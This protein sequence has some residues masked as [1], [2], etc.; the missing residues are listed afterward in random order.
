MVIWLHNPHAENVVAS[1]A[2][3]CVALLGLAL[4]AWWQ[5]RVTEK[6]WQHLRRMHDMDPQP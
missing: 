6:R 1:Y 4:A 3:V 2:V 5:G